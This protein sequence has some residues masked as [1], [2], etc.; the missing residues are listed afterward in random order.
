MLHVIMWCVI[1]LHSF[2]GV[3][4]HFGFDSFVP[5]ISRLQLCWWPA[6]E[7]CEIESIEKRTRLRLVFAQKIITNNGN[8]F[9]NIIL[10]PFIITLIE[11][12][13]QT[14]TTFE[15][16]Y[17]VSRLSRQ[18]QST[19]EI[20]I[21]SHKLIYT[22][23]R[24]KHTK[25]REQW[26]KK[27][28]WTNRKMVCACVVLG[29]NVFLSRRLDDPIFEQCFMLQLF[30]HIKLY[31]CCQLKSF[32]SFVR[33]LSLSPSRSPAISVIYRNSANCFRIVITISPWYPIPMSMSIHSHCT[34]SV[35][36]FRIQC[37]QRGSELTKLE[38]S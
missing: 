28:N 25:E 23:S 21:S 26:E 33:A 15:S 34:E 5:F 14:C 20:K 2:D 32:Y 13:L 6:N 9:E 38:I 19:N 1:L 16:Y 7:T 22:V 36:S 3:G 8:K 31:S 4:F 27:L 30:Y 35:V 12:N 11:W 24:R 18:K 29:L 37:K 10:C 17:V